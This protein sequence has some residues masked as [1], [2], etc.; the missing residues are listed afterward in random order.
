MKA[1]PR[2]CPACGRGGP[3]TPAESWRDPVAGGEDSLWACAPCGVVFSEPRQAVGPEWYEKAAPLRGR[4]KRPAPERDWRFRTFLKEN[5][6]PGRLLDVGC[7][8]GG[9]LALAQRNGWQCVGFDYEKRMVALAK[10]RGVEVHACEFSSFCRSRAAGEFDVV[11][12]FDVLE[13]TP[14]PRELLGFVLP[15]LKKGGYLT[16]TMP[17]ALRPLPFVREEHDYPPH[18]FTRWTPEAMR[19]FLER[20]GF[21]V[22]HQDAG[23]LKIGY[24]SDHIYFYALMPV[25]LSLAKR[26]FFG[27]TDESKTVSELYASSGGAG[28]LADKSRRQ[29]LVDAAKLIL[30]LFTW[31]A[32]LLM[33]LWYR[34]TRPFPGDCLY[35]LA[36]REN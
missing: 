12:L 8:D 36:R 27:K 2:D 30:R 31:P 11:A 3:F 4:E 13:H 28:A 32:A 6:P 23:I 17:N 7:G 14:E 29:S 1:Q 18:H 21:T 22:I 26:L 5:L 25:L 16:L 15:L 19:G 24:L 34:A 10:E 33:W 20:G 9:F 35:T